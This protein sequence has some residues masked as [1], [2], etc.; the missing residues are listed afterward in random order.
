[1]RTVR[2]DKQ[3]AENAYTVALRH[4]PRGSVITFGEL[5]LLAIGQTTLGALIQAGS[6]VRR[7]PDKEQRL[8]WWRVVSG[9]KQHLRAAV[10][11]HRAAQQIRRLRRECINVGQQLL[12]S[13]D[14][15]PRCLADFFNDRV[16]PPTGRLHTSTLVYLHGSAF[17]GLFYERNANFFDC[18][19]R[20]GLRIVLPTAQTFGVP[21]EWF[22]SWPPI[23]EHLEV[24]R[25]RI[26][27][28]LNQERKRLG[29]RRDRLFLGGSS[30]G[31]IL[32]LDC[33]ARCNDVGGF[34]GII[35]YYPDCSI[36]ALDG[37]NR[38][39]ASRPVR[40]FNGTRDTTVDWKLARASFRR[41]K[42][43]ARLVDF[44][45]K[46][47]PVGHHI[48]QKEGA[49]IRCFLDELLS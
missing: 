40:C 12:R 24:P 18:A 25:N 23:K 47:E 38:T 14:N 34:C 42:R 37:V 46:T 30:Q 33:F 7:I 28:L 43:R 3:K 31:C 11:T 19:Q 39:Q 1:M 41:L 29:G 6:T 48:G 4:V 16:L 32:G 8:P 27:A 35:G 49:W 20:A 15:V 36:D 45:S 5:A 22:S 13:Y 9:G 26:L 44:V 2:K 17:S 10:Q 21:T